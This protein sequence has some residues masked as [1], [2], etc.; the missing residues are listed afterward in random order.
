MQHRLEGQNEKRRV[1]APQ[2]APHAAASH[3][4]IRV[5]GKLF[6]GIWSMSNSWSSRRWSAIYGRGWTLNLR[7]LDGAALSYL[8]EGETATWDRIVS[9]FDSRMDGSERG[10]AACPRDIGAWGRL[11]SRLRGKSCTAEY[12]EGSRRSQRKSGIAF[13]VF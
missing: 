7:S 13:L 3:V 6:E 12:A 9:G 11:Q 1:I 5:S 8:T 2:L 10:H 4:T